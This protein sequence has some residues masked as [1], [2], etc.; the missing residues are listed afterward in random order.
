[1]T[2]FLRITS[3]I[4]LFTAAALGSATLAS[5]GSN[6]ADQ[7]KDQTTT[8]GSAVVSSETGPQPLIDSTAIVR[9]FQTD[10]TLKPQLLP[11]RRFYREREFKLGWFKNHQP[12]TQVK[13]LQEIIAKASEEGL[14]PKDFNTNDISS[15]LGQLEQVRNDAAKRNSLEQKLDLAL[16]G[17]YMKWAS[18]YYRGIANPRD[19]KDKSW[20]V[21]PNKIKL[22]KALL[23]FLGERKSKYNYY[24]FA[25]LHPEY[26]YLKKALAAYRAQERAGGWPTLPAGLTLKPGQYSPAVAVLRKRLLGSDGSTENT[27][28]SAGPAGA[29]PSA[30]ALTYDAP[31]VEAVKNFQRDAGLNADGIVRGSTLQQLNVSI[32]TRVDQLILNME[33]WRWLPKK[34]E[35][36]YLLVNIPEYTLHVIESSKEAFNMR[37]IVGKVL[38][39]TPVFSDRMEYVVLAPYWNVPFSIIDNELRSKL[40]ADPNYLDQLDMEVVKGYGKKA[41]AI[42]PASVDWANVTEN[43]FKYTLRRRPGPKNDLGNVKFIFPNDNDIYLHDTPHDELFSQSSR[44]FSH[45]CVRLSEPIKLAAYLLRKQ[46]EWDQQ[47]ILDSIAT[48]R[49]K[50]I[51]LKEKLPVYLVYFT[52]WADANGHPHFRDDVYGLDKKL[53]REYF[54]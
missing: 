19:S 49:E 28:T 51:T 15:M 39:E 43:T 17:T 3:F 24:E 32:G 41:T 53:A 12:V 4:W 8:N 40:V 44:S 47:T 46:P 29:A 45:G 21:K 7:G 23:T 50:Y 34:F 18:A 16:T 42:D 26:D 14:N 9:A 37:V 10:A 38:H 11:A 48:H 27:A 6:Q 54:D 36:D 2:F 30:A 22:N 25:P 13:S 5:C 1:M 52:A 31:L 35:P 20:M 33:R